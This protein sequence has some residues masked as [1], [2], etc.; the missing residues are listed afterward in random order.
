MSKTVYTMEQWA[1]DGS[2]KIKVG[3]EVDSAV[4]DRLLNALPPTYYKKGIFQPGE[5][6]C[7]DVVN[8]GSCLYQT[9]TN[10]GMDLN[11]VYRGLCLYGHTTPRDGLLMYVGDKT[12]TTEYETYPTREEIMQEILKRCRK[13]I[14]L[15]EKRVQLALDVVDMQRCPLSQADPYL[16]DR[17]NDII[18]EYG[19]DEGVDTEDITAD[20]IIW[21]E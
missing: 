14:D 7:V 21:E 4:I 17:V 13:E 12:T 15:Y 20:D 18:D 5:A 19:E 9:F 11:W 1:K 2:L 16:Y 3:Q 6:Y 10:D 8:P